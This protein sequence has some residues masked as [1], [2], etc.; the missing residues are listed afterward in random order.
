M[1]TETDEQI[2]YILQKQ[3]LRVNWFDA[4]LCCR[5]ANKSNHVETDSGR[6]LPYFEK[7]S[8]FSANQRTKSK[9]QPLAENG[10]NFVTVFVNSLFLSRMRNVVW[11]SHFGWNT[12]CSP[13]KTLLTNLC[14]KRTRDAR[15]SDAL[16]MLC[17]FRIFV[18]VYNAVWII[19]II[20]SR[21]NVQLRFERQQYRT[22][23]C[24]AVRES[25]L[26]SI[27]K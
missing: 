21:D 23:L 27:T 6:F 11:F 25:W 8:E 2:G 14:Q 16:C 19:V 24:D 4:P 18:F 10:E 12:I 17:C 1:W 20:D 13:R 5:C 3:W 15:Q 7:L 9:D 26:M 22:M